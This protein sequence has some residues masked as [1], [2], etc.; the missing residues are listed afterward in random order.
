MTDQIRRARNEYGLILL[1]TPPLL[2][3][4]DAH[5][6]SA[7]TDTALLVVQWARTP[8]RLVAA[9][10]KML[11]C[12]SRCGVGMIASQVDMRQYLKYCSVG[13]YYSK[14][15]RRLIVGSG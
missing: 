6:L 11:E 5:L 14:S 12:H 9:A 3:V 13:S 10:R 8:S 15:R 1:D 2:V 7:V 4:A